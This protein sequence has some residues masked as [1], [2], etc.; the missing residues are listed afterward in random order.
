MASY[1]IPIQDVLGLKAGV[2]YIAVTEGVDYVQVI[3]E[4]NVIY[5][6]AF[7]DS[8]FAVIQDDDEDSD[9]LAEF[10]AEYLRAAFGESD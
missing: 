10:D 1:V 3:D 6:V 2:E 8:R 4:D 5:T 9:L 7:K